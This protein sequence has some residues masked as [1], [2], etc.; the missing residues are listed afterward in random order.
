MRWIV[1]TDRFPDAVVPVR[2]E[3]HA[4]QMIGEFRETSARHKSQVT[5]EYGWHIPGEPN[6]YHKVGPRR[7]TVTT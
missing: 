5:W 4:I 6:S 2:D 1:R 3:A 7:V